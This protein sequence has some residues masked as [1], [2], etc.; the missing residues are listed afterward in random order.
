[1]SER[2][3]LNETSHFGR[4]SREVLASEIMNR[5]YKKVLFVTDKTLLDCGVAGKV[6][7]VL[8]AAGIPYDTYADIK[9]NPTVKNVQDGVVACKE[10]GADVI[11]AVGGGSVMD[12]AKGISIIMTNPDRADVVS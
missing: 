3:V 7:A 5:G 4:G 10:A 2:F 12:T 8:D 1:M 11:V 6:S 9:P